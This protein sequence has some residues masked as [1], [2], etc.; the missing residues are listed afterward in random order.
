ME[1]SMSD[2][3]RINMDDLEFKSRG[4][5]EQI[6]LNRAEVGRRIGATKL[7]YGVVVIKPGKRG[8]PYHSHFINE[9]MFFILEGEGTLRHAGEEYPLRAGDFI[10]SPAGPEQPH[11]IINTSD[12][13]LK[14]LCVSTEEQPEI[15]LYPDSDKFGVYKGDPRKTDDPG[16]FFHLGR[17]SQALG[18]FDG[19]E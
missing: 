12:A 16:T 18:Y 8:W 14:Y 9:E 2:D 1:A 7:G 4:H 5:G 17:A 19:E 10:A 3:I 13:D 11:Q 15:C 6:E